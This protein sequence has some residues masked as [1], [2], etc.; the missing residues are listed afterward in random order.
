M[1]NPVTPAPSVWFTSPVPRLL[2]TTALRPGADVEDARH[3][4]EGDRGVR[5]G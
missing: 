3:P 1:S 2:T 4:N 5:V